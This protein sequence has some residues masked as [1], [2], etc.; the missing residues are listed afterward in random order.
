MNVVPGMDRHAVSLFYTA[1]REKSLI[2]SLLCFPI[3][4]GS[5]FIVFPYLPFLLNGP[6]FWFLF[7]GSLFVACL[8]LVA[9]FLECSSLTATPYRKSSEDLLFHARRF[10]RTRCHEILSFT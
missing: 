9:P 10:P 4:P 8:S 7:R 5:L 1:L 6:S 3:S 2:K